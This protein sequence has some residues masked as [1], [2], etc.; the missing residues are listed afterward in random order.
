MW[1]E[2]IFGLNINLEKS[3][4]IPSREVANVDKQ[5][6]VLHCSMRTLLDILAFH[7]QLLSNQFEFGI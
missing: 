3:K 1:F 4:L 5:A 6:K 2:A 7:W